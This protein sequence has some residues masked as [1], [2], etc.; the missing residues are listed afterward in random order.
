MTSNWHSSNRRDRLPANWAAIAKA[1]TA[2]GGGACE[3]TLLDGT[4]CNQ[5]PV[6]V[7]H[8]VP[9]ANHSLDNLQ[10]LCR[11]WHHR[12]KTNAEARAGRLAA[13]VPTSRHP[14][15]KHPSGLQLY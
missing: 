15:E 2:R 13:G 7:D 6:D 5:S 4:R 8:I 9:G 1:A 11:K 3:A 10:L 12:I 14:G